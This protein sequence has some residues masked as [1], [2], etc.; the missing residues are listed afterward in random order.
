MVLQC[1]SR[2]AYR[3]HDT[4]TPSRRQLGLWERRYVELTGSPIMR[5]NYTKL[6]PLCSFVNC[7]SKRR[8][9]IRICIEVISTSG[10]TLL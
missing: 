6:G 4:K 1:C 7:H 8:F 2:I 9:P 10:A 5:E 3:A